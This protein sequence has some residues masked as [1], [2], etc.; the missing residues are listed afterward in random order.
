MWDTSNTAAFYLHHKASYT[1]PNPAY[2]IGMWYPKKRKLFKVKKNNRTNLYLQILPFLPLVCCD[3][4]TKLFYE[5]DF[6]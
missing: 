3:Y 4:Q 6:R 1:I 5:H 2:Y